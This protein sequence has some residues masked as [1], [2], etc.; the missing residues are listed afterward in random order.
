MLAEEDLVRGPL[1]SIPGGTRWIKV[2]APHPAQI[3]KVKKCTDLAVFYIQEK[4]GQSQGKVGGTHR[5]DRQS[6]LRDYEPYTRRDWQAAQKLVE[7][8]DRIKAEREQA[9]LPEVVAEPATNGTVAAEIP[10]EIPER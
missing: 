10:E 2:T 7:E 9:A 8:L 1:V 3:I 6:F 4:P 5:S